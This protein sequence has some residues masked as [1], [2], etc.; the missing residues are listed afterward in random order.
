ML[1]CVADFVSRSPLNK[2]V[3]LPCR[4][5]IGKSEE[6]NLQSEGGIVCEITRGRRKE[7]SLTARQKPQNT[8]GVAKNSSS[9]SSYGQHQSLLTARINALMGKWQ[10]WERYDGNMILSAHGGR[11]VTFE[12]WKIIDRNNNLI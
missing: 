5:S 1:Q 10:N 12:P 4:E 11:D 8:V 7:R 2:A 3:L 6:L 9:R